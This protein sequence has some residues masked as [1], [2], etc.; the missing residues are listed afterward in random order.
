MTAT[1]AL[2][3]ASLLFQEPV[4]FD[5]EVRPLLA[6]RC[7]SCH[8]PDSASRQAELRLDTFE[9]ATLDRGEFAAIV[10]GQ[11]ERSELVHRIRSTEAFEQ[12]PPPE[13]HATPLDE[14]E[15]ELLV[16]WIGEG[17]EYAEH[18]AF[19][20]PQRP[21]TAPNA[22]D[23]ID[24]LVRQRLAV[25]GL[26]LA[27]RAPVHTL[28]RRLSL[29]LTG[30]PPTPE[31]VARLRADDS[32]QHWNAWIEELLASHHHAERLAMWWLDGAR[33]ADT[34]G[35]QQDAER[36]SWPWRD[37]V[38]DAF[39]QNL[40]FDRF[41]LLQFAGDLLPDATDAERLAT[42]L[43]RQHMANGE[44]G[45]DA[46]E[47]RV[48]Y[49][50]DRVDTTGTLFLGLT[51]G[52]AQCHDHKFDPISQREYYRLAAYFDSIDETGAAGGHAKP[53]IKV[54]SPYAQ[55]A[56]DAANEL[57]ERM[58]AE[59]RALR[60]ASAP[61]ADD[62]IQDLR[63]NLAAEHSAWIPVVPQS[64]RSREGSALSIAED[65]S[66]A[67]SENVPAQDDYLVTAAPTELPSIT[68]V[69]LEVLPLSN[70]PD[71]AWSFAEDGEFLLTGFKV[72]AR[73][74]GTTLHREAKLVSAVADVEGVAED[75]NYKSI[76]G[77]LDDDPRTGWTTRGK[78]RETPHVAVF[79]LAEPL[80]L[81]PDERLE[82]EL[83]QR[84]L[85]PRALIGRFRLFLTDEN[86]EAVRTVAATPR[87]ELA[88]LSTG[89]VPDA[90]RE[91]L[92]DQYL[93]R[94]PDWRAASER[95]ARAAEQ[96]RRAERAN[97]E[98][99][100]Q[101][102]AEREQKRT[103]HVLRRGVWDDRGEIVT[104]GV[105]HS[106]LARDEAE[107]P[108]RRELAE[109]IVDARN[110]LTARAIVNQLWQL[111]FGAG[112]VRTPD[113]LGLRG[114]PPV[115]R[116]VLDWLAVEFV[117]SGWDVRHVLRTIVTSATYQQDSAVS[118]ELLAR[119]PNNQ[120]LA[121][122]ARF[123]LPAWILRD[124]ALFASG[125]LNDARGGPPVFPP[126]PD[127]VWYDQFMGRLHYQPTLGSERHRRTLYAFWRRNSTPTFLFDSAQRREC[128]VGVRRTNTPLHALTLWNDLGH[129][130][131]ARALAAR[132]LPGTPSEVAARMFE[133]VLLRSPTAA[134]RE[135]LLRTHATALAHY[136][137]MPDDAVQLSNALTPV[138]VKLDRTFAADDATSPAPDRQL[139]V[140][141]PELAAAT[142]L[143]QLV[144]NLD[145]AL[146]HE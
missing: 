36:T 132:A 87:E 145:E 82:L 63:S 81:Q 98:L 123:R 138:G 39:A 129:L 89:E 45:R 117:E 61:A 124:S 106:I 67:L 139:G 142:L 110:P 88:R 128:E 136:T 62:W 99:T 134:E 28:A 96:R 130:E 41:T 125:L 107:V 120:L 72:R 50:R 127:G 135:A 5:L 14:G 49:V 113:D 111:L 42:S 78:G 27:P 35:F 122:G 31:T 1:L 13:S 64:L 26:E 51:L 60:E 19:V 3:L 80:E 25:D 65:S 66:I 116:D 18:W 91:R 22:G 48:D 29:D 85:F 59:Q 140:A 95:V 17:A 40:P 79:A 74:P 56:L 2:S 103:T 97:G 131:A 86:G 8:G 119:D 77:A 94:D 71:H 16:R 126:Q 12:M 20:P 32:P 46:E 33:Y 47:S 58:V 30:L 4:D 105:P 100:V 84:S 108:T 115:H 11:P 15:I 137:A 118:A 54:R 92:L 7:F 109:W 121:R 76:S 24:Q 38:V 83:L 75:D 53:T 70:H 9:G 114:E 90:L 23:P 6:D 34:D 146:T 68:G 141:A 93:E 143:A 37:W 112:L 144:L 52:C 101:V 102:L 57:H 43:H 69:R 10:P 21:I 73:R 133:R 55:R 44:G 104:P